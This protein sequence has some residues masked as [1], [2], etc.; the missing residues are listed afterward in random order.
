MLQPDESCNNDSGREGAAWLV[1]GRYAAR[2]GP[3]RGLWRAA[4]RHNVVATTWPRRGA[5]TRHKYH[6][7]VQSSFMKPSAWSSWIGRSSGYTV[8]F[9]TGSRPTDGSA[10]SRPALPGAGVAGDSPNEACFF[11]RRPFANYPGLYASNVVR[12]HEKSIPDT[13]NGP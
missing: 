3:L 11:V 8:F 1:A 6:I 10:T 12:M 2:G 4:T 7:P 5:A 9:M 13:A